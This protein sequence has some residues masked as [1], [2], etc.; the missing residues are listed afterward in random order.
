M[1]KV[2]ST[3]TAAGAAAALLEANQITSWLHAD[4]CDGMLS[5]LD[6]AHGVKL[7]VM[8]VDAEAAQALLGA[9]AIVPPS[10][11]PV[12]PS[13]GMTNSIPPSPRTKISLPQ[14]AAGIVLGVL[15]CLLYQ[16][17]GRLGNKTY[18]FD[19]TKTAKLIPSGFT[20]TENALK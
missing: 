10:H 2:F 19:T 1:I 6:A 11:S 13:P 16:W 5:V 4:D 18:R 12:T 7:L 3:E 15:L 14:V 8:P 17:S 20:G 9:D